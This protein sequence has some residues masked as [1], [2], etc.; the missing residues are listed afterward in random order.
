MEDLGNKIAKTDI[1]ASPRIG[2]DYAGVDALLPWRFT[3]KK[4][5]WV[6]RRP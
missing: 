2:I 5:P 4:N 3:L 6:S 1:E